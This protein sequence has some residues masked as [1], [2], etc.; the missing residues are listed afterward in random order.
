M[1]CNRYSSW[2]TADQQ[3]T[4]PAK[5]TDL[6][7]LNAY[8]WLRKQPAAI[9]VLTFDTGLYMNEAPIFQYQPVLWE[10]DGYV[11]ADWLKVLRQEITRRGLNNVNL[12][13]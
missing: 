13:G 2:N 4:S 12:E 11:R 8:R 10:K 5:M 1:T 3:T 9:N 6:H 7:L